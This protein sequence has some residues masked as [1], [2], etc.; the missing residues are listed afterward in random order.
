VEEQWRPVLGY[1]GCYEAS[2]FGRIR[3][4]DRVHPF[5]GRM[6]RAPGRMLK[7]CMIGLKHILQYPAVVLHKNN[8]KGMRTVHSVILET[9]VGPRPDKMQG[10][11]NDGNTLNN[12]L[13]NLRYATPVSNS[14]DRL[15][16]NTYTEG[17]HCS[18]AIIV[19]NAIREIL[20]YKQE[21]GL[22][23]RQVA[24]DFYLP[25]TTVRAWIN[26]GIR[27][28]AIEGYKCEYVRRN[29]VGGV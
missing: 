20:L 23:I 9:F 13:D 10:A 18:N 17:E 22:S 11:H 8:I 12:R 28:S 25:Y 15:K 3:S 7:P 1:E 5:K 26:G 27:R 29:A 16:H 14:A 19:D 24:K 2:N 6:R 21:T 4:L